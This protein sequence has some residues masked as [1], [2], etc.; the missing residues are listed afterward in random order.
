VDQD[1]G[2]HTLAAI[3]VQDALNRLQESQQKRHLAGAKKAVKG[4]LDLVNVF[5][6]P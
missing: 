6:K 3:R 4:L 2:P 1:R 5:E